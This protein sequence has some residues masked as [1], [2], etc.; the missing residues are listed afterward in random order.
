MPGLLGSEIAE[1]LKQKKPRAKIILI[2]AFADES[3]R[4]TASKM[5]APLISKPFSA[6]DL[7]QVIDKASRQPDLSS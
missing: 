1:A 3:L 7:L 2:S 4:E 6:H 5:G